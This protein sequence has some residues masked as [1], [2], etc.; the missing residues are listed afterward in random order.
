MLRALMELVKIIKTIFWRD[1]VPSKRMKGSSRAI[2]REQSV[3]E[4][5]ER[6]RVA[7]AA[8]FIGARRGGGPL[9]LYNREITLRVLG[10]AP[11]SLV[12]REDSLNRCSLTECERPARVAAV[13]KSA[14]SYSRRGDAH[15]RESRDKRSSR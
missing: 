11:L 6:R 1:N 8:D 12:P 2:C 3:G 4:L 13:A 9:N 10:I 5:C 7:L 14:R 15:A